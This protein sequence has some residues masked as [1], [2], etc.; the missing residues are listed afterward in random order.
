MAVSTIHE[1]RFVLFDND[2]QLAFITSQSRPMRPIGW[3]WST[4]CTR[5]RN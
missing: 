1:A 3:E 2:T 4:N 5:P